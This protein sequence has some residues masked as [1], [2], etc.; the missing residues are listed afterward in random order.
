MIR[1]RKDLSACCLESHAEKGM[2]LETVSVAQSWNCGSAVKA[3]SWK[4]KDSQVDWM[5]FS[6][7]GGKRIIRDDYG[8]P[9]QED[10]SLFSVLNILNNL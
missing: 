2:N 6:E 5:E 7:G 9:S 10:I 3:Q 4:Q 8:L 1:K